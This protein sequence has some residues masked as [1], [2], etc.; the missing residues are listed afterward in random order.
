MQPFAFND[1]ECLANQAHQQALEKERLER[2]ALVKQL[3][4]ERKEKMGHIEKH[5]KHKEHIE[6]ELKRKE[7]ELEKERKVIRKILLPNVQ[8]DPKVYSYIYRS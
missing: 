1:L 8:G 4:D 2:E 3:E 5:E 7:E 6:R